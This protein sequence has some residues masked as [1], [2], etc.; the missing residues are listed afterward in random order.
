[1]AQKQAPS[2]YKIDS[3]PDEEESDDESKPK[4]KIPHW[5]SSMILIILL[6]KNLK[7]A[8]KG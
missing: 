5:A 4:H 7:T 3:D 2:N 8:V 6:I 1:M